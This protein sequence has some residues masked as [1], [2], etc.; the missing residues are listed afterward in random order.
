MLTARSWNDGAW[1]ERVEYGS[2]GDGWGYQ[3]FNLLHLLVQLGQ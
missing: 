1:H 2:E 3:L